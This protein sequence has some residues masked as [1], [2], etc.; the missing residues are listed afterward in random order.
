MTVYTRSYNAELFSMMRE[1]IP[2]EVEIVQM[3]NYNN[4]EDALRF[5]TDVIKKCGG[6]AVIN[7]EDNFIHNWAAIPQMIE[8]MKE[9]GFTHA[10]MPD[11][12]VSPHRT[13]QW[14]TLNPFFNIINCPEIVRLGGLDKTDK[15]E[16]MTCPTFEIFDDL[17]LQM[18][19][20]GR[21]LYLNGSTTVDG[22]TTHL[23]DHTGNYFALHSWLSR[24]WAR[25]EKDRIQKVYND[26]K[27]YYER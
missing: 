19:K 22:L 23:Q 4:W 18:W 6:W 10:G 11:R 7:D 26:A 24:E 1:F 5:I 15:P 21:P 12:G 14:T 3:K 9:N 20:V 17:Y 16:F 27:Y 13:L 25:G 2:P 8:Y